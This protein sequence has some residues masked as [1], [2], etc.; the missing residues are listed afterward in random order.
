MKTF[1]IGS[2]L[3]A[4]L[5]LSALALS[6]EAAGPPDQASTATGSYLAGRFAQHQDDWTAAAVYTGHA[7]SADPDDLPLL[8]RSF[9][10]KLGEGRIDEALALAT[11]TLGQ[12]GDPQ[13]ALALLAADHLVA[14]RLDEAEATTAKMPPDGL[15]KF[16]GPLMRGWLAAG[17]GQTDR[18]LEALNP[19]SAIGGFGALYNLH[20]GLILDLAGRNEDAA[21]RYAKVTETEAPLR[22]VQIVGN[23]LERTGRAAEA[24]KL[25]EA[26]QSG[27]PD[28]Q[29]VEPA[30]KSLS[31]GA[32]PARMVGDARQGMAEALF[33]LGSALHHE[34]AA[35]TALLFGR[36]ALHLRQDMPLARLMIGDI[37]EERDHHED[38]LAEYKPLL[39]N[40]V[41]GWTARMRSVDA[42]ARMERNDEAI[43]ALK[44]L[45][46]ERPE[47]TDAMIRLGDLYRYAKRFGEAADTYGAALSRLGTPQ[48]RHW[49]VLYARA[50][51][52]E[53]V[54]RWPEAE[55]DLKTALSLKPEEASL[56]NFLGYSWIDRGLNLDKAKAM[57]ERA[58]ELKPR[59]GYIVDSLGW[60]LFSLGDYA[61]AVT[62]LERAVELKPLDPTINDHLGDAYWR[63]GRRN[64]ARF[65]WTR[66]LR[67]ADAD[68]PKDAIQEKLDK[69]LPD[70][71]AA[72]VKP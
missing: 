7:L 54:N 31:A 17:R 16:V 50:M 20:A 22:V 65:Q 21:A 45:T 53:K 25:Y 70:K 55:A 28:S 46:A 61:G 43:A 40:P 51:A 33:D 15:G 63:V 36:I 30:L 42:L 56:L 37:M 9:L 4:A 72:A 23:F 13:M 24:R 27:S 47:R 59:D 52:L 3:G 68:T 49:P 14:G 57:V 58:V 29:L 35:E 5:V 1:R 8:R 2:R 71:Q 10:L 32:V 69:G 26:F 11:R 66:A 18:A 38:A 67:N 44:A 62:K 64:E 6:A 41:L 60:A 39:D 19:L 12:D 34:G 48:E